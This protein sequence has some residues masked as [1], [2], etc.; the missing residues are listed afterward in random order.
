LSEPAPQAAT[1]RFL[2]GLSARSRSVSVSPQNAGLSLYGDG[3]EKLWPWASLKW[4][5]KS[6]LRLTSTLEDD[7]RLELLAG[8]VDAWLGPAPQLGQ[9]AARKSLFKL[10]GGLTIAAGGVFALVF[11]GI[12]AA[13]VPLARATP[14]SVELQLAD[15]IEAQFRLAFKT[16]QAPGSS[17]AIALKRVGDQ[18]A[19][20]ADLGFPIDIRVTNVP[21]MNAFALPGGRV[22]VTRGLI[23][24]AESPDE[25]AAVLSHEI[26]HVENHD[27]LVNVYRALGFGLIL[28][29]V[30]GGGSGAGQQ[31]VMLGANVTDMKHSREVEARS[32]LRGMQLLNKAGLDSRGMAVF[33]GRL[34]KME[35][36]STIS[37]V[38]GLVAS[39]PASV[40]RATIVRAQAKAGQTA[41]TPVEWQSLRQMC[42]A[43]DKKKD[44]AKS[45]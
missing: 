12:P 17:G 42:N 30:V 5:D 8:D 18:L 23:D 45:R 14:A 15:S 16:C 24:E 44:E 27:V 3:I 11:F 9:N 35:G 19:A 38:T 4:A 34:A 1:R 31:L 25:L 20:G 28:D 41:M 36:D 13:A 43:L 40:G 37:K 33:F 26:A 29:A 39:H 22:W 10:V 32:D 7:A 6:A 21:I 2:D